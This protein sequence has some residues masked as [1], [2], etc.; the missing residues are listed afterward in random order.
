VCT[1]RST[2]SQPIHCIVWA[3][4]YLFTQLFGIDEEEV[5]EVDHTADSSNGI[6][7]HPHIPPPLKFPRNN[8]TLS[9]LGVL[10]DLV[11][12]IAELKKE[13]EALKAVKEAMGTPDF[14]SKVFEKVFNTDIHRLLSMH[15]MWKSR[16]PPTPLSYT[17]YPPPPDGE[18][19]TLVA[20][21]QKVWDLADNIAVFK[22]SYP[23][24]IPESLYRMNAEMG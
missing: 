1:I 21:D 14:A 16:K 10:M 19:A 15:D 3:K 5:P 11:E 23:P 17:D 4:S 8:H 24:P 6:P 12:E 18:I 9:V 2:P 13:A 20:D 7:S 22:Y